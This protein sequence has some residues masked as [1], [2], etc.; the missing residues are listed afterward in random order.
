[1][2]Y[3][4]VLRHPV[5]KEVRYVGQTAN[6]EQRLYAHCHT[7]VTDTYKHRWVR[8]LRKQQ[9]YPEMLVLEAV[10]GGATLT[11]ETKLKIRAS[12][13]RWLSQ[14]KKES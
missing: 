8:L 1:M 6:L 9:L 11:K 7:V 10:P 3:I 14:H 5:T 4:Y 2:I 13:K 12:L